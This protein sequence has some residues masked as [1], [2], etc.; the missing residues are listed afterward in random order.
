MLICVFSNST[1]TLND[2]LNHRPKKKVKTGVQ[3]DYSKRSYVH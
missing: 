1:R 3:S 2:Q